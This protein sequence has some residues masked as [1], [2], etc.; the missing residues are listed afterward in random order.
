MQRELAGGRWGRRASRVERLSCGGLLSS[1]E[2]RR[3]A[4]ERAREEGRGLGGGRGGGKAD[5]EGATQTPPRAGGK[6]TTSRP[7][8]LAFT[9][10]RHLFPASH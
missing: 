10:W 6:A 3:A 8:S 2:P 9:L 4:L 7:P 5:G 1:M